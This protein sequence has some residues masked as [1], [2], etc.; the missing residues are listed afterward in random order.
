MKQKITAL[1][2]EAMRVIR[3]RHKQKLYNVETQALE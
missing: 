3:I 2:L 1:Q